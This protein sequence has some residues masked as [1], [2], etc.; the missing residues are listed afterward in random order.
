MK[1]AH[2]FYQELRKSRICQPLL[3]TSV[4]KVVKF[5]L[6]INYHATNYIL[7]DYIKHI[8]VDKNPRAKIPPFTSE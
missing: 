5:K 1:K 6:K 2:K 8:S 4:M 7:K 3:Y